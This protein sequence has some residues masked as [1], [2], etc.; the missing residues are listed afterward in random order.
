MK[1]FVLI[2]GLAL[3]MANLN[4]QEKGQFVLQTESNAGILFCYPF[5]G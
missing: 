3:V 5:Q 2:F 4:A 1:K